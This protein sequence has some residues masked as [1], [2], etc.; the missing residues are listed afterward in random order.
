MATVLRIQ[1]E[2][3]AHAGG[4]RT[5]ASATAA[6]SN[7][8]NTD[9]AG[10][11]GFNE[12]FPLFSWYV[13]ETDTTRYKSTGAHVV[14]DAGG[15]AD[16]TTAAERQRTRQRAVRQLNHRRQHGEHR[17][18]N[19]GAE[20][21]VGAGRGL[22]CRQRTAPTS[23]NSPFA[24]VDAGRAPLHRPHRSADS[25]G[26]YGWQGFS[27]Q[28]NFIEFGKKP[29]APTETGGIHGEVIYA[30]TRPFDDPGLLIHTSW[31]PDVPGRH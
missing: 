16:G 6:Y 29:Y 5:T 28:N 17:G 10:N 12:I 20:R 11:A 14:Y 23:C 3:R 7:F 9:L 19:P 25:F 4:R 8:N 21:P 26:S 31:T 30:S 15:P 22:L 13:I 2:D 24:P 18:S 27:G 1:G